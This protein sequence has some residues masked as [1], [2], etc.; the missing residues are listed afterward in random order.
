MVAWES[1]ILCVH[2]HPHLVSSQTDTF[3]QSK[4]LLWDVGMEQE[5]CTNHRYYDIPLCVLESGWIQQIQHH[6]NE[7]EYQYQN[8]WEQH[9]QEHFEYLVWW[10]ERLDFSVFDESIKWQKSIRCWSESVKHAKCTC[11]RVRKLK[12]EWICSCN[13]LE[14]VGHDSEQYRCLIFFASTNCCYNQNE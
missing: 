5:Y 11:E 12:V 10:S 2:S 7:H 8:D 9:G 1:A 6:P 13:Q 14:I 3:K 4:G